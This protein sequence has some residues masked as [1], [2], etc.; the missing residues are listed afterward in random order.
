MC[1]WPPSWTDRR[2]YNRLTS[3][4]RSSFFLKGNG[5]EVIG[6]SKMGCS[7]FIVLEFTIIDG[8]CSIA[9]EIPLEPI[10]P[11]KKSIWLWWNILLTGAELE[12]TCKVPINA[13]PSSFSSTTGI[14]EA[15]GM[16]T[17]STCIIKEPASLSVRR[18]VHAS[19]IRFVPSDPIASF[20]SSRK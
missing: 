12:P 3:A 10:M 19:W 1:R 16:F 20:L 13:I 8:E 17:R 14:P 18:N 9:I 2:L 6:G 11:A 4:I 7:S 15:W 5:L